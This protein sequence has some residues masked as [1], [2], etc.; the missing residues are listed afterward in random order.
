M[1]NE[2]NVLFGGPAKGAASACFGFAGLCGA[3]DPLGDNRLKRLIMDGVRGP[4][5]ERGIG[6]PDGES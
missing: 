1:G 2:R 6:E 4:G 5:V 3:H